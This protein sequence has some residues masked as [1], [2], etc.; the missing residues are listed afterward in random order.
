MLNKKTTVF[1]TKNKDT[2]GRMIYKLLTP[3]SDGEQVEIL[4]NLLEN[5]KAEILLFGTIKK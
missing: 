1:F 3:F 2:V 5:A 4:T